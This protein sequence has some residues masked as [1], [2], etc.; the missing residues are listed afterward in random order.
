[1]YTELYTKYYLSMVGYIV[2]T[3]YLVVICDVGKRVSDSRVPIC[4]VTRFHDFTASFP[5]T[6]LSN[7]IAS[8]TYIE[9]AMLGL[10]Y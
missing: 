10:G 7:M 8:P 4:R 3:A 2:G 1:M 9:V 6:L 5:L